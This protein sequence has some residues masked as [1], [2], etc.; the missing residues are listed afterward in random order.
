MPQSALPFAPRPRAL[1]AKPF[2]G[3][4]TAQCQSCVVPSHPTLARWDMGERSLF[5]FHAMIHCIVQILTV[6]LKCEGVF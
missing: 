2:L 3:N 1:G 5:C 4:K 6:D